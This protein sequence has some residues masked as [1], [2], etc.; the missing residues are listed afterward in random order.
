MQTDQ[1]IGYCPEDYMVELIDEFGELLET[2]E[3]EITMR[4][5]KP[6]DPATEPFRIQIF[7]NNLDAERGVFSMRVVTSHQ[8]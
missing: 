1:D 5:D 2:N 4:L 6:D 7:N 3:D 8:S